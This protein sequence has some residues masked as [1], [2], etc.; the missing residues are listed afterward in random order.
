[1]WIVTNRSAMTLEYS[2]SHPYILYVGGK[3]GFYYKDHEILP[4]LPGN[5][6]LVSA[7]LLLPCTINTNAEKK[8]HSCSGVSSIHCRK[9]Q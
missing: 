2:D 6:V 4:P 8:D 1:M 9:L 3:L 5:N 7:T